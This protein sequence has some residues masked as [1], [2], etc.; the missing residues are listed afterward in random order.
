VLTAAGFT[1]AYNVLD[2]MEGGRVDD[3]DSVVNGMRRKNGWIMFGL[4]WTY[5]RTPRDGAPRARDRGTP[6]R[7]TTKTE[8]VRAVRPRDG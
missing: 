3:H 2:G 4:P 6:T 5:D 7:Q 8:A 1:N